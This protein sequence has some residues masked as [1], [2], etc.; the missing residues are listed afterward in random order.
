MSDKFSEASRWL[1]L[2]AD[3]AGLSAEENA[4]FEEWLA[5]A[6]NRAAYARVERHYRQAAAAGLFSAD[7][8]RQTIQATAL[9]RPE[10][11]RTRW[12]GWAAAA[13]GAAAVVIVA[14]LALAPR[15]GAP[16]AGAMHVT[17][18]GERKTVALPDGS[19]LELD[20]ETRFETAFSPSERAIRGFAGRAV[21]TVEKDAARPFTL[22][23][24]SAR[25][26]VIGTQFQVDRDQGRTEVSVAHGRVEVTSTAHPTPVLLQAGQRVTVAEGGALSP[27]GATGDAGF[28]AWRTGRIEFR[29]RPLE[30]VV[31]EADRYFDGTIELHGEALRR[32]PISGALLVGEPADFIASLELIAPVQ[33]TRHARR[34]EI[35]ARP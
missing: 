25:V 8:V 5:S 22:Q 31:R 32:L 6:E 26:R 27:V 15:N 4:R 34:I 14:V 12:P 35:R 13:L 11:A 16:L 23:A 9:R 17:A 24:G 29:E 30:E 28:A 2:R 21:F 1:A 20:A 10:P 3:G 18:F 7:E 19:Q 33:V